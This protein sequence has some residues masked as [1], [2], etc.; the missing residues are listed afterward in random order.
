MIYDTYATWCNNRCTDA[1][2][3][4]RIDSEINTHSTRV[5][6]TSPAIC[7]KWSDQNYYSRVKAC[8]H[9]SPIRVYLS[10]CLSPERVLSCT[11]ADVAAHH[12][13]FVYR[14]SFMIDKRGLCGVSA[15]ARAPPAVS[16]RTRY[17]GSCA[18]PST[19]TRVH[20][21]ALLPGCL[22]PRRPLCSEAR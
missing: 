12:G 4:A 22:G 10:V 20:A 5:M 21:S 3:R 11:R 19:C 18:C 1:F 17:N 8:D 2:W 6:A 15:A 9:V 13:P 14:D 7:D 16:T